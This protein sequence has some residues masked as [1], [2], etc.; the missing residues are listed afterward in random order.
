MSLTRTFLLFERLQVFEVRFEL[1]FDVL[2]G[3]G[4]QLFD[5]GTQQAAHQFRSQIYRARVNTV[6][7][8]QA[9]LYICVVVLNG[10]FVPVGLLQV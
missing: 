4:L 9:G 3:Q 5:V 1:I 10:C 6:F 7:A 8:V 2:L